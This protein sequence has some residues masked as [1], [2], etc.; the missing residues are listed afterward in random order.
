MLA[1]SHVYFPLRSNSGYFDTAGRGRMSLEARV[2][3]MAILA[4]EIVFE[5]GMLT[6]INVM[7]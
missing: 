1:T 4:N 7:S 3:Q 5:E 2:K 6:L